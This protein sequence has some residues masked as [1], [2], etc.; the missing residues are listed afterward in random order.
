MSFIDKFINSLMPEPDSDEAM[1]KK[2]KE[3]IE[4]QLNDPASVGK[5]N[6]FSQPF[7][8]FVFHLDAIRQEA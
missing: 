8:L 3:Q 7:I 4:K 5:F 2:H 1:M 6:D